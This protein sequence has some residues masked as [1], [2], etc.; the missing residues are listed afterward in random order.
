MSV[1]L[2]KGQKVDLT[3]GHA[4]LKTVRVGLGWDAAEPAKAA[5][6]FGGLLGGKRQKEIDC[7][8][9]VILCDANGK[10]TKNDIVYFGN[11]RHSSGSVIHMG[12]NLTGDG[13][14]DD[15]QIL[16]D[17]STMPHQFEKMVFVVNIYDARGRNQHFGMIKNA[18]IR[19]L[20][21]ET[22]EELCKYS[23][24]ENYD[25]MTAMIFGEVYRHNGEWKFSAIG[26]ATADPGL[27]EVFSRY[28]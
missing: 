8:A 22:N 4:G 23:L 19:L 5:G 24:S 7:D 21:A 26:Q 2:Q 15:E 13:D 17:L 9:S 27:K 25:Q 28:V 14:G 18:F 20:N 1:N 11:L 3:K 10:S 16:V 12:D 6:L